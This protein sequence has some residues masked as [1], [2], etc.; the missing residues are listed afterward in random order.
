[1]HVQRYDKDLRLNI[2]PFFLIMYFPIEM[3]MLEKSKFSAFFPFAMPDIY[4]PE[5]LSFVLEPLGH[6]D[7]LSV[8]PL[9]AA[10]FLK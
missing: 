6:L 2:F 10:L 1:M 4:P 9:R 5:K 3:Y 7:L 8:R